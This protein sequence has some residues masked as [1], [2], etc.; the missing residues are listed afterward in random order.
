[1]IHGYLRINVFFFKS[2]TGPIDTSSNFE[3]LKTK[4]L[5]F[6]TD[7]KY[8]LIYTAKYFVDFTNNL[9]SSKSIGANCMVIIL[10]DSITTL[11]K[12]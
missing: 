11:L 3:K 6:L 9:L 4:I 8:F 10:E 5:T 7:M 2:L 1:M 12:S